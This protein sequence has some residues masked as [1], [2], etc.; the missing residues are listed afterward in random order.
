MGWVP[1]KSAG[2]GATAPAQKHPRSRCGTKENIP[3]GTIFIEFG[4]TKTC[5]T[6]S[7]LELAPKSSKKLIGALSCMHKGPKGIQSLWDHPKKIP[8]VQKHKESVIWAII[9]EKPHF[10]A[11]PEAKKANWRS[12]LHAQRSQKNSIPLGTSEKIPLCKNTK[13]ARYVRCLGKNPI[14][15]HSH[16]LRKGVVECARMRKSEQRPNNNANPSGLSEKKVY[17]VESLQFC[18]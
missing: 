14:I 16:T 3:F 8:F 7:G 15:G 6:F 2:F 4:D 1:Q 13:K 11:F 17:C 12:Q 18:R 9:R 10:G 5:Y